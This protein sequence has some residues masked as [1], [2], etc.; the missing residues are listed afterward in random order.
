VQPA[1]PTAVPNA[2]PGDADGPV[3][4]PGS[5]AVDTHCHLFLMEADPADVVGSARRAG[6]GRIVCVGIDPDSS[7]RSLELAESFRGVFATAGV[8]PHT[9]SEFDGSAAAVVEELLAHPLVVGAGETGL[10][11]YRRLSPPEDQQRAFRAHIALSRETGKPLVVHVREAWPE[12]LRILGEE[13]AERVVLHCFSGDEDIA[14]EAA[15]R[16]YFVSFAGNLTYPK[17]ERL[18]AA[19][20]ALPEESVLAET[21]SPFLA[22]QVKRGRANHPANV[23]DVLG[24]LAEI[25]GLNLESMVGAATAAAFGAFPLV[26]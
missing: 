26:R 18:R 20:F 2:G 5:F 16:G 12:A 21:D 1:A 14:G 15:A 13:R 23:V 17:N 24:T 19:A 7:R 22:P 11:F 9:A 4:E 8:H 10:D 6:V 3:D 25:R